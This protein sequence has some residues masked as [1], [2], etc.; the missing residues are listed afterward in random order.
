MKRRKRPLLCH[1]LHLDGLKLGLGNLVLLD[2]FSLILLSQTLI[3]FRVLRQRCLP[4]VRAKLID[5]N[6]GPIGWV[7]RLGLPHGPVGAT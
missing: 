5:R 1:A 6:V 2:E 7:L 3:L 4:V